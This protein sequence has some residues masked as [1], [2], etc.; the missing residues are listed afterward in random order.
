[1]GDTNA[2]GSYPEGASPYGALDMAG[3]VAKWVIDWYDD[4]YYGG[5]PITNPPGPATGTFRVLRGGS[6]FH[7][8]WD[9]RAATRNADYP[10]NRDQSV[11]FRCAGS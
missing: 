2:V 4:G 3:N 9:L 10:N 11:G 1:M 8:A 6:W 7:S 5:W